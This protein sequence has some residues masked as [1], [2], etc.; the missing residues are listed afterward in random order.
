MSLAAWLLE[1]NMQLNL[2]GD[3]VKKNQKKQVL[4]QEKGNKNQ[5][6]SAHMLNSLAGFIKAINQ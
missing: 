1:D 3:I 6:L 2:F 4:K 5:P